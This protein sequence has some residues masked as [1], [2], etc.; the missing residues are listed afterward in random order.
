MFSRKKNRLPCGPSDLNHPKIRPLTRD[1]AQQFRLEQTFIDFLFAR[2]RP[3][4]FEYWCE[5]TDG[6]WTC[7]LPDKV[8]VA[9][10]LWG[11]N[12]DQTLLLVSGEKLSYAKGWHDNN[13][14]ERI[15]H[16]SQG[17]LANLM[18]EISESDVEE[19]DLEAAAEFCGFRYLAEYQAFLDS[20]DD[21]DWLIAWRSFISAIDAAEKDR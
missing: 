6:G 5:Q 13:D 14:L 7:F 15:A 10:P 8:D 3:W 19:C 4:Y 21:Q 11:T 12:A 1:L 20:D 18:N 2:R 9:Y 16:T 17:L